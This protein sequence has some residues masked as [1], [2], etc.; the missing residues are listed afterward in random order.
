MKNLKLLFPLFLFFCL[1]FSG[2]GKDEPVDPVAPPTVNDTIK[3]TEVTINPNDSA[4]LING[5]ARIFI[6]LKSDAGFI[7]IEVSPL[8]PDEK[9][10]YH[11][12]GGNISNEEFQISEKSTFIMA[13]S[14]ENCTTIRKE[15]TI[16]VYQAVILPPVINVEFDAYNAN[17]GDRLSFTITLLSGELDSITMNPKVSDFNGELGTFLTDSIFETTSFHLTAYGKGGQSNVDATITREYFPLPL[18]VFYIKHDWLVIQAQYSR[19]GGIWLPFDSPRLG[20]KY[21]YNNDLS[22]QSYRSNGNLAEDGYWDIS[23]DGKYLISSFIDF[24]EIIT[25][26]D[27]VYEYTFPL[28]DTTLQK[29]KMVTY[30]N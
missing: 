2:C 3:V 11:F 27:S 4:E 29:F 21:V 8:N 28:N 30:L 1:L 13:F 7:D 23:A 15:E 24:Q 12:E 22:F 18:G 5:I 16:D 10:L 17:Y 26:N 14:K 20:W 9:T 6:T 25:I 19:N